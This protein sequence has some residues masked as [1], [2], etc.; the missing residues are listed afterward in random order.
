MGAPGKEGRKIQAC[1]GETVTRAKS[2]PEMKAAGHVGRSTAL[3][4][5][6]YAPDAFNLGYNFARQLLFSHLQSSER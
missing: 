3:L 5:T 6:F 1:P 4:R 2:L